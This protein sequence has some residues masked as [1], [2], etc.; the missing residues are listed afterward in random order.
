MKE[1][2]NISVNSREVDW[3][4]AKQWIEYYKSAPNPIDH[5]YMEGQILEGFSICA[6]HLREILEQPAVT[7]VYMAFGRDQSVEKTT[8]KG[9]KAIFVGTDENGVLMTNNVYDYCEP[10]PPHCKTEPA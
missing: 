1:D 2:K 8:N 7:E 10:C 4:T 9:L 6:D 3:D 5:P